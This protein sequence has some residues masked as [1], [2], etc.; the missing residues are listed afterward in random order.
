MAKANLGCVSR[1]VTSRRVICE[2]TSR[3]PSP[4]WAPHHKKATDIEGHQAGR[5]AG[6]QDGRREAEGCTCSAWRRELLSTI[7]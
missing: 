6:T 5:E 2:T 3:A 1:T 7:N 4:I